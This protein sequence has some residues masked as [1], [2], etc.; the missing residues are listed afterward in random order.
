M[1]DVPPAGTKL[2]TYL[3]KVNDVPP[4]G[5]KLMTYLSE[6][7]ELMYLQLEPGS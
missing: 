5:T 4:A 7:N 2:V 3:S 6:M 1:N